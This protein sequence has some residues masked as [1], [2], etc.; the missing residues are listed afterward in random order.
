M[1]ATYG[2]SELS[3]EDKRDIIDAIVS[4][5][6]TRAPRHVELDLT[7]RCNV[8]C[9]FCNQQD[10]RTTQQLSLHCATKLIDELAEKGLRAV[11]LSGGGDPLFHPDVARV[12][13]HLVDRG[14]DIDNI[15]TN[16]VA[17][18]REIAELLVN[19][20]AREVI[21]SLNAVDGADYHRM[22]AVKPDRFDRVIENVAQ[23]VAI[24]GEREKPGITL[25]FLLDRENFA[26]FPEMYRLGRSLNVDRITV[27]PVIEIPR[28]RVRHDLLLG[29][30]D[31]A[32]LEPLFREVL[33][34]DR[35]RLLLEPSYIFN[36]GGWLERLYHELAIPIPNPYPT[37]ETFNAANG[38]CFFGWYS[39]AVT[40]NGDVRP[41]CYLLNP[42]YPSLGN[43]VRDSLDAVWNSESFNELRREMRGVLLAGEQAKYD[44]S[45]FRQ[46]KPQCVELHACFL[47][48]GYF[49]ADADFYRDL[50]EAL[51]RARS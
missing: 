9:Y 36:W 41:C 21:V 27:S 18:T 34:M 51:E 11:R 8:A 10:L 43:V 15:T 49:R 40:G 23:L 13:A 29:P 24:R 48:N 44:E 42:D 38:G 37:A 6:A 31:A 20:K 35:D 28:E 50:G 2:W 33:Q 14:V 19:A 25:Q 1:R 26:R 7:D 46:L 30:D 12:L 17:L 22:M 39:M 3:P 32:R 5:R 4:G 16:G 47:K 45:Q